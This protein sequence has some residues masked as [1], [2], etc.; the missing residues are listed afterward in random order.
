MN[1]EY[2][3]AFK[4][5]SHYG[6]LH[7]SYI[8]NASIYKKIKELQEDNVTLWLWDVAGKHSE[9]ELN[10]N[11]FYLVSD[12]ENDIESFKKLFGNT[13]GSYLPLDTALEYY[14]EH[15]TGDEEY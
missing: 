3:I 6:S 10:T 5:N 7:G 11:L 1:K 2:L 4:W 8:V 9:V 14:N 15:Y 12:K 13:F